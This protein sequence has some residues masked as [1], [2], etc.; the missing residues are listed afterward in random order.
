MWTAVSHLQHLIISGTGETNA[1]AAPET[2]SHYLVSRHLPGSVA[3]VLV[4][5][6][7]VRFSALCGF[8]APCCCL[9]CMQHKCITWATYGECTAS[10]T[11]PA[12]P[13]GCRERSYTSQTPLSL[14]HLCVPFTACRVKFRPWQE[15]LAQERLIY[16]VSVYV[17]RL[18]MS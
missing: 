7:L 18:W 5:E 17:R 13:V 14:T 16:K 11:H 15:K 9:G 6:W 3:F 10:L 4:E 12:G 8:S 1:A 2:T